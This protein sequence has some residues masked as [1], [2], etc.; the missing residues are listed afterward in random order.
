MSTSDIYG[1]DLLETASQKVLKV[2]YGQAQGATIQGVVELAAGAVGAPS[3]SFVGDVNTGVYHI[4]DGTFGASSNGVEI[5]RVQSTGMQV[6]GLITGTAVMQTNL[7]GTP[8][9]LMT[10]GAFGIGATQATTTLSNIDATTTPSGFHRTEASTL[11]VFPNVAVAG[12]LEVIRYSDSVIVQRWQDITSDEWWSRR[13]NATWTTWQRATRAHHQDLQT[14]WC[15]T[16]TGTADAIVLTTGESLPSLA[17]GLQLRFRVPAANTA[18]VT[19]AID[20]HPAVAVVTPGGGALVANHLKTG[21]D[22][23]AT[24]DGTSLVVNNLQQ[25]DSKDTTAG[26]LM[27]TEAWGMGAIQSP[28]VPGGD[29]NLALRTGSYLVAS[30]DLNV[31]I[32]RNGV[33]VVNSRATGRLTQHYHVVNGGLGVERYVRSM[34]NSGGVDTWGSWI[35]DY[36]ER[37]NNANGYYELMPNG[38]VFMH[39]L[40]SVASTGTTWTFPVALSTTT[41]DSYTLQASVEINGG[42]LR[43]ISVDMQ[44]TT[45]AA[46]YL[47]DSANAGVAGTVHALLIGRVA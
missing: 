16:A 32:A 41:V 10:P 22:I 8:G 31:P 19:A 44:T 14:Y 45:A 39:K 27:A 2:V 28:A 36:T 30:T 34:G 23:T 35:T 33:L 6:T 20:G 42:A 43:H 25:A 24:Y 18:A 29:C 13:Y 1:Y 46:F 3:L 38:M 26:A 7:D 47:Y 9:R 11:G 4:A 21:R 37:L 15:G 40:L 17:T 5:A 12:V